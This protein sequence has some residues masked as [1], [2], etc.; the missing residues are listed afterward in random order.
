MSNIIDFAGTRLTG[1]S[2]FTT[3]FYLIDDGDESGDWQCVLD[4]EIDD[5]YQCSIFTGN[6]VQT[7]IV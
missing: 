2:K 5:R 7:I 3:T 4:N 6:A 1:I